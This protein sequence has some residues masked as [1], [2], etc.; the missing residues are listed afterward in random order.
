MRDLSAVRAGS[1]GALLVLV[2]LA[3][4]HWLY[5]VLVVPTLPNL[6]AVP[7]G[8]W[9]GLAAPVSLAV[10][11]GGWRARTVGATLASAGGSLLVVVGYQVVVTALK[12]RPFIKADVADSFLSVG[13][14]L[15]A[16]VILGLAWAGHFARIQLGGVENVS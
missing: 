8:W 16:V 11:M 6:T 1:L 2:C 5:L 10:F 12:V 9:L 13:M 14:L 15:G 3:V 7:L 4:G